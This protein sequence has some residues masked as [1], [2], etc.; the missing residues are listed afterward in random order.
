M[1][2]ALVGPPARGGAPDPMCGMK[3]DR[4]KAVSKEFGGE[5]FYFCSEHC[6]HAYEAQ[7]HEHEPARI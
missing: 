1:L 6:L 4:D 2:V 7:A 3:V 5:M